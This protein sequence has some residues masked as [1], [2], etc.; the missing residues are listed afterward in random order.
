MKFLATVLTLSVVL[1]G[2]ALAAPGDPRLI[3]G[4]L[5]WPPTLAGGELFVVLHGA[6]GRMYSADVMAAQRQVQGVLS[7]G[8][9]MTLLGLEGIKSHEILAVALASGDA[10]ALSLALA[11]ATRTTPPTSP[12]APATTPAGTA[13]PEA[14][15]AA[16]SPV[17]GAEGRPARGE[18][19]RRVT[20]RG[21]VLEVAGQTLFVRRA[22]GHAVGIDMSKLD[23]GGRPG[24]RPGSPV[25]VV[26]VPVGNK[27]LAT[28]FIETDT[29]PSGSTPATPAH[30]AAVEQPP[31]VY[32]QPPVRR[33]VVYP[34][35][36]YVLYGDG[37]NQAYQWVW[38][39]AAPPV[40]SP[41]PKQ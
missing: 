18:D 24:L 3:Q 5:E 36:K 31:A 6:D 16:V 11:Q 33:Q 21:S 38:I 10:T 13:P 28:G 29:R 12:P 9:R 32:Q 34:H 37:V 41:T 15:S 17:R 27:F 40:S 20:L 2:R 25:A 19:G 4:T 35:G 39:Q 8:S 1:A 26:V 30:P 23:P 22:D 14:P 7:A